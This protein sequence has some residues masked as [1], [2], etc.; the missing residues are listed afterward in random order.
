MDDIS[1][2]QSR[3]ISQ[4]GNTETEKLPK[5]VRDSEVVKEQ[6]SPIKQST[7]SEREKP[8]INSCKDEIVAMR[9]FEADSTASARLLKIAYLKL[10][11]KVKVRF[12]IDFM[13][14][15]YAEIGINKDKKAN[16]NEAA[17][18]IPKVDQKS[19][20]SEYELRLVQNRGTQ[21]KGELEAM[22]KDK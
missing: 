21:T 19:D 10:Y 6:K 7:R 12:A 15:A 18:Q 11:N 17:T 20:N 5:E 16:F 1:V 14:Q 4:L 2:P 3:A 13:F 8:L 22:I 9:L